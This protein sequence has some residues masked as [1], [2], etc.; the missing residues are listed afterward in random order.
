MC[1]AKTQIRLGIWPVW[2]S[3]I[4]LQLAYRSNGLPRSKLVSPFQQYFS[5]IGTMEGW[6]WKA[7]CNET[8]F[9]KFN[10]SHL[11]FHSYLLCLLFLFFVISLNLILHSLEM[12]DW[13]QINANSRKW[14]YASPT[15]AWLASVGAIGLVLI[16]N[17]G[18]AC[19][20]AQYDHRFCC[21]L[22][23]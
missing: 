15:S 11:H 20:S 12:S 14:E 2:M 13:K 23:G 6:T 3:V 1:P 10:Y 9:H 22:S 16:S 18:S 7:L 5:H 19:A 4:F 17:T 8:P 21:S